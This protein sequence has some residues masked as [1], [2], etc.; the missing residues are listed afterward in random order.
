[1]AAAYV[2]LGLRHT[3]EFAQ[4][5]FEEVLGMEESATYQA[6]VR[7]GREQ[8]LELGRERGRVEGARRMLL[9]Q[10]ATKFGIPDPA[11]RARIEALDD[12]GRL[13]ELIVRLLRTD[14]WQE[15]LG[16]QPP[17]RRNGRRRADS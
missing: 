16:V 12:F 5:L 8:G 13:E 9:L 3:D 1:M 10:G 11:T 2:L 6:I 14:S 7:R 15:L 17:R 4:T